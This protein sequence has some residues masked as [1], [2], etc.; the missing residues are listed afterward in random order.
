MENSD[1][2]DRHRSEPLKIDQLG[3][4]SDVPGPAQSCELGQAEP[5]SGKQHK[6]GQ[7]V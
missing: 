5:A 6:I 7:A 3:K 2:K 1:A 4:N